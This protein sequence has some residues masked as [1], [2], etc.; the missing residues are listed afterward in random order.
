MNV[1]YEF[2][3]E[4]CNAVYVGETKRALIKRKGEHTNNPNP[5]AVINMHCKT[6]NHNFNW[7]EPKIL[8]TECN[9][10]KRLLSEMLHIKSNKSAVKILPDASIACI[11]DRQ[12]RFQESHS[13]FCTD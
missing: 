5:D 6:Y 11:S 12:N 4:Q 13:Q 2:E 7:E 9:W 1:V 10:N 3:Y 8:D